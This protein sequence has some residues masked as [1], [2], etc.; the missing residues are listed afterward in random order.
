M[1]KHSVKNAASAAAAASK[2][3]PADG[4]AA[5]AGGKAGAGSS[6]IV[7]VSR[8]TAQASTLR[9]VGLLIGWMSLLALAVLMATR[10]DEKELAKG[11]AARRNLYDTGPILALMVSTNLLSDAI[12][13][14]FGLKTLLYSALRAARQ[15]YSAKPV[16]KMI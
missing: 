1:A 5:P 13:D 4:K 10:P 3:A 14:L 16:A 7:G 11:S 8:A 15:R 9:T 12:K 2:A 6:K